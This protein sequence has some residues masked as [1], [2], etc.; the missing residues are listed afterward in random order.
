MRMEVTF[1]PLCPAEAEILSAFFFG[2]ALR[3][4]ASIYPL[5]NKLKSTASTGPDHVLSEGKLILCFNSN[6]P[7]V[8]L[9][10]YLCLYLQSFAIS[11]LQNAC[12]RSTVDT[13]HHS[14]K[15]GTRL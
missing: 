6:L 8:T 11:N 12:F 4:L 3:H 10:C 7:V 9:L 5:V 14:L 1:N 15:T 2:V 13:L